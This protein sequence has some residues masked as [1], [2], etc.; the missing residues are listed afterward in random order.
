MRKTRLRGSL[1]V[2]AALVLP[3]FVFA[4][5]SILYLN[6][7]LQLEEEV[8]W[9]LVRTAREASVEYAVTEKEIIVSPVYLAGKMNRYLGEG[10]SVSMWNSRFDETTDTMK[11]CTEYSC[12][13][14]F[15]FINGRTFTFAEHMTTRAFTGVRTRLETDGGEGDITVYVTKNG[16]VYHRKLSCTHLTLQLSE[17]KYSDLSYLRSENGSIY[18]ACEKC[19]RQSVSGENQIV[20]ICNFGD[21]Y[22]TERSCSKIKRSIQEIRLSETGGRRPCSKCGNEQ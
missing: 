20:I 15:P 21:R 3:V 11:L 7:L 1:T 6:K 12:Q 4:A 18:Y 17:V 10:R 9:A 19:C 8:Q 16:T 14:P 13:L 22:H 5:L 2:E